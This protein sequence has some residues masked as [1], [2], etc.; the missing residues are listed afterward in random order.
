MQMIVPQSAYGGLQDMPSPSGR[1]SDR[2]ERL[3]QRCTEALGR[4]A[5]RDAYYFLKQ[6]EEV[7][8][9]CCFLYFSK[10]CRS[11][12]NTWTSFVHVFISSYFPIVPTLQESQGYDNGRDLNDD[13]YEAKK[14]SRMRA[15]LGEGKAHYMSLIEQ[16][17]FMEETHL[18]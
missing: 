12:A 8:F 5:F 2:I 3:R 1:L 9:V 15:I 17:I 13:D 14:I 6:H 4:D 11:Y 16:L 18:G 10:T 7:R